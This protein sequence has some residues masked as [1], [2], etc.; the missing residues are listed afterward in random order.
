MDE[1]LPLARDKQSSFII[2][3]SVWWGDEQI[4]EGDCDEEIEKNVTMFLGQVLARVAASS[5]TYFVPRKL[6]TSHKTLICNG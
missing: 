5:Y 2:A 6:F 4:R 1:R 3:V